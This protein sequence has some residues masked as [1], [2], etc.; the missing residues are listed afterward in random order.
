MP[1]SLR[2]SRRSP[3]VLAFRYLSIQ[4]QDT[5]TGNSEGT[6]R[7]V[8]IRL[9]PNRCGTL[10]REEWKRVW[11]ESSKSTMETL[12]QRLSDQ[13]SSPR[14]LLCGLVR[15]MQDRRPNNG[16][17][18]KGIRRQGKVRQSQRGQQS[19]GSVK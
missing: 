17:I 18:I 4:Q 16:N 11:A 9:Y 12:T 15:T 5:S 19:R 7:R 10:C 14:R 3:F 13:H 1:V 2:N 8:S 6:H